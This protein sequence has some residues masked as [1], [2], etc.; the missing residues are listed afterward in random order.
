MK[1]CPRFCAAFELREIY[2]I[3]E[4]MERDLQRA[5]MTTVGTL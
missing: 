5:G 1:T 4:R 2:G 3:G